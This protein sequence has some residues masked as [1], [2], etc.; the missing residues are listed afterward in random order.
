MD[1]KKSPPNEFTEASQRQS[2]GNS[3]LYEV[4]MTDDEE[5]EDGLKVEQHS[6]T[7]EADLSVWEEHDVDHR[8]SEHSTEPV[9]P[10]PP[11]A[12]P[13][14]GRTAQ[15]VL[16]DPDAVR[17]TKGGATAEPTEPGPHRPG[18]YQVKYHYS[19]V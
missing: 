9:V 1:L 8:R 19:F 4:P 10:E 14:P 16:L 7:Y 6:F 5:E 17:V 12:P 15:R 18:A 13:T 2:N 11:R 3:S